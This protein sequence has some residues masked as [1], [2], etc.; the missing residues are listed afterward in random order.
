MSGEEF[1]RGAALEDAPEYWLSP[2]CRR[3]VL[4]ANDERITPAGLARLELRPADVLVQF[5]KAMH[6]AALADAP[7]HK[8]FV[9][10]K[11]GKGFYW[12]FDSAGRLGFD[13][14]NQRRASLTLVFTMRI[15]DLVEPF[16]ESVAQDAKVLCFRPGR[17]PLFATPEG[18]VAS[19]GFITLSY[20]HHLNYVRELNGVPAA[21]IVTLG[22]TG[23]YSRRKV[24]QGHD[25]RF[26]QAVM[27]TWADVTRLDFDGA[28]FPPGQWGRLKR[29]RR[30]RSAPEA[31]AE[32]T[33]A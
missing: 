25:F 20:F 2:E 18:S 14:L 24:F 26:E 22:F 23:E 3:F 28:P 5:N 27:S 15:I 31:D 7:C 12:G 6:F 9:F 4:I 30:A 1:F 33:R 17:L 16:I 32:P 19:V 13:V 29:G 21:Q 8:A 10:Q 11:N